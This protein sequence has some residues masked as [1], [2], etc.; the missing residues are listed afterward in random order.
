MKCHYQGITLAIANFLRPQGKHCLSC[1][2]WTPVAFYILNW[3]IV[4]GIT[5]TSHAEVLGFKA[6][7]AHDF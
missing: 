5:S 4:I 1:L 6:Q 3:H 7:I 2:P